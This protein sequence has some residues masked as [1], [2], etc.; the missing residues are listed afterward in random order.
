LRR[1]LQF[2]SHALLPRGKTDDLA[3]FLI[4]YVLTGLAFDWWTLCSIGADA[5]RSA[6][7]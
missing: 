1:P 4:A 5:R 3:R 7:D 2:T 6:T